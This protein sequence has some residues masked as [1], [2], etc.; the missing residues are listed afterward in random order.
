[1]IS[2]CVDSLRAPQPINLEQINSLTLNTKQ[3]NEST[4]QQRAKCSNTWILKSDWFGN[5]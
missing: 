3:I 4:N 1:L 5:S 2:S